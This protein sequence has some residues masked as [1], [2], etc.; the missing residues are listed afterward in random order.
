MTGI[1]RVASYIAYYYLYYLYQLLFKTSPKY[2]YTT[3]YTTQVWLI[4]KKANK[5]LAINADILG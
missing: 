1:S 5:S 3:T 2:L 4:K